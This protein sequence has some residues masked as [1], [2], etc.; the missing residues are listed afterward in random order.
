MRGARDWLARRTKGRAENGRVRRGGRLC[1]FPRQA[2]HASA[3]YPASTQALGHAGV[4]LPDK[5]AVV[6]CRGHHDLLKHAAATPF[7]PST[8]ALSGHGVLFLRG[9]VTVVIYLLSIF[10]R[11]LALLLE[12]KP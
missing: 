6:A 5:C 1:G 2:P 7:C 8:A 4:S 11:H 3:L 12:G 9:T 10:V